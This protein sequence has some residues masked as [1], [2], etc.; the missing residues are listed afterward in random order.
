[1]NYYAGKQLI[2]PASLTH[3]KDCSKNILVALPRL[4]NLPTAP[5]AEQ[6]D[7]EE[8]ID[9]ISLQLAINSCVDNW[10]IN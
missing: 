5:H 1:M 8:L 2:M 9:N 10:L 6:A 7:G 4:S 3:F